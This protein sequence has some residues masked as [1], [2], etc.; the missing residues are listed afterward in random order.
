M[1]I[2]QGS[3]T[4][5]PITSPWWVLRL[6]HYNWRR[7]LSEVEK[8]VMPGICYWLPALSRIRKWYLSDHSAGSINTTAYLMMES[9]KNWRSI[10]IKIDILLRVDIAWNCLFVKPNCSNMLVKPDRQL[11]PRAQNMQRYLKES[12]LLS[13]SENGHIWLGSLKQH[14][15]WYISQ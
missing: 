4:T 14:A 9:E 13:H 6:Q 3:G 11:S 8:L 2:H 15:I 10:Y 5:L 1:L 12:G 7:I